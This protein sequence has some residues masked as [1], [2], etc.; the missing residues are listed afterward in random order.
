MERIA[1]NLP[2]FIGHFLCPTNSGK[3]HPPV[4]H[5][6]DELGYAFDAALGS[7]CAAARPYIDHYEDMT[8]EAE[9]ELQ[10]KRGAT[11]GGCG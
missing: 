6:D 3:V 2:E 1:L 4:D 10:T 5:G 8:Y 11:S 7:R 9:V